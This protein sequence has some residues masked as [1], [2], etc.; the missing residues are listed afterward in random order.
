M[1]AFVQ[2]EKACQSKPKGNLESAFL[3]EKQVAAYLNVSVGFLRKCRSN[4]TGI[5]WVKFG[6]SVRYPVSAVSKY[7]E[8]ARR[9]FTG[10][11]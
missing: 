8:E 7:I 5:A 1:D 11:I 6:N 4:G 9:D 3:H 2:I 10:Q